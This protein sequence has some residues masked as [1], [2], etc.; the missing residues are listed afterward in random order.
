MK[1]SLSI[2]T[3]REGLSLELPFAGPEDVVRLSQRAEYL[4]YHSVWG[5][6][7]IT[8]PAYVREDYEESP[9]WF[10]PL[11][12]LAYVAA[13]TERIKLGTAV[14]VLPLRDP[15]WV[16]K[17]VATLDVFSHGR[18]MLTVGVGAY[19]EEFERLKPRQSRAH[20]GKMLTEGMQVLNAIFNDR[21]ASFDGEYYAFEDLEIYPK[22]VQN[23]FPLFAGGNSEN[24]LWRAAHFGTGWMAAS[25]P[26]DKLSESVKH[27]HQL[28][29]SVG[30]DPVEFEIAPQYV[31]AMGRTEA[32]ASERFKKSRMYTHLRTLQAST[33]KDEDF[34]RVIES[35]LIGTPEM[36]IE[37]VGTLIDA[38]VTM[39][40]S[41]S[42]LSPNV[43]DMLEHIQFFAEEVM[44]AFPD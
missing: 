40:G 24:E 5:N 13:K 32:E 38:G 42:F 14:L 16:A 20:R 3:C 9:Q 17:Q 2:P 35:N 37:R 23:P 44:P 25:L 28:V 39:F 43:E 6:D 19:R 15:V 33:L 36:I 29:Y 7:H 12:T 10:E 26:P 34:I 4:G 11:I 27:F 18:M 30:R 1:F 41:L 8:P 31:V 21:I 22:P